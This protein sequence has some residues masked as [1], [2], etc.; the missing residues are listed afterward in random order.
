MYLVYIQMQVFVGSPNT[1]TARSIFDFNTEIQINGTSVLQNNEMS[2]IQC[3]N[4]PTEYSNAHYF[5]NKIVM[6]NVTSENSIIT[7]I[8]KPK[9]ANIFTIEINYGPDTFG[10]YNHTRRLRYNIIKIS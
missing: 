9:T 3:Y 5:Y 2:N 8:Y 1:T 4:S 7:F 10:T 6:C